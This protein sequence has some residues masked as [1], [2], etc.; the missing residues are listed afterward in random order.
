M[1]REE[2]AGRPLAQV[3]RN[4]CARVTT[5]ATR[6]FDGARP[7]LGAK[8]FLP[9]RGKEQPSERAR[10]ERDPFFSA[11]A[12]AR[13]CADVFLARVYAGYVVGVGSARRCGC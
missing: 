9:S 8:G 4:N 13:R 6:D 11:S 12:V 10:V 3:F 7:V 1:E 5:T 2:E